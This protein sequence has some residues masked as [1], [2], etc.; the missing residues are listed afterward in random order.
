MQPDYVSPC[1]R[2]RLYCG[3]WLTLPLPPP[4]AIVTDPPY[5][6]GYSPGAGGGGGICRRDGSHYEK[7]FTVRDLVYGDDRPFDP[8]PLLALGVPLILW[9]G[10]HYASR[11]PD[12]PAWLVWDKRRG[13]T[14]NDFADCELA[15]SNLPQVARL[16][17]LMWNGMLR[18]TERGEP[19]V[20]PTQKPVAVM[21][22]CL[23][24]L[25]AS[26]MSI[27]DPYMGSGTTGVACVR[28]GL[29]FTGVEIVPRFYEV[30]RRRIER[31]L[32]L[33]DG[34]APLTAGTGSLF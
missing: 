26:A 4:D 8:A 29:A 22:W 18:D 14:R 28:A 25:P 20:H 3:D 12:S 24:F 15:W 5:G 32:A 21:E 33:R 34:R 6:I 31:E 23:S 9:G 17:P 7:R 10:N 11:L 1:G 13:T 19:R 16:L 27:L 2:F 30:A